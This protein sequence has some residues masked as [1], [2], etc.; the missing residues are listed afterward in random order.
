MS[1]HLND[2]NKILDDLQNL[3]VEIKDED[4]ALLLLNSLPDTYDYLITT[5][6]YRKNEIKFNDVSNALTNNEYRKK[7]KQAYMD[8]SSEALTVKGRFEHKKSGRRGRSHSKSKRSTKRKFGKD[9]CVFCRNKG[10]W[11]KECPLLKNKNKKDFNSNVAHSIDENS[12]FALTSSSCT[13][14]MIPKK[15]WFY[16]LVESICGSIFMGNDEACEIFGMGK[17]KLKLYDGT[18]RNLTEVL[19]IPDLKRI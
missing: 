9:E 1:E 13:F 2:Y 17:I 18:V 16:N 7:D 5:L 6:L 3:E 10:H 8:T 4:K 12:D 15:E 14:H 19:Y 11:K